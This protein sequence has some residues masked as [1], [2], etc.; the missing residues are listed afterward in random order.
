[1]SSDWLP[2]LFRP[3]L[4][5]RVRAP[6][7]EAVLITGAAQVG[8]QALA[9]VSG[10]VILRNLSPLQYAY[11][12]IVNTVLG[13]MTV[14]TDSGASSAV[15]TQGGKV[16][17]N[18]VA[19]G[20]VLS[21]GLFLRRRL[22]LFAAGAGL[23]A[24][25]ILL[26]RQGAPWLSAMFI[27]STVLPSFYLA[28]SAQLL[29][30]VPRLH[31]QLAPL[32]RNQLLTNLTRA[33]LLSLGIFALPY[34]AAAC[35]IAAIPQA[36]SNW[37]LRRLAGE[38]ADWRVP[39]DPAVQRRLALQIRRTMPSAIYFAISGQLT[40]W[41]I[42]AFGGA[43]KLATVGAL[44]RLAVA[45][46]ILGTIFSIVAVPRYARI[47]AQDADRIHRRYWQM[48][49]VVALACAGP[50]LALWLAPAPVLAILGPHYSRF[51]ADA[52]LMAAGGVVNV[53][54]IAALGLAGSRGV[55]IPP[56][57]SIPYVFL[58]QVILIALLPVSTVS[59]VLWLGLVS[60]ASHWLLL[61][62]YFAWKI[63]RRTLRE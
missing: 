58:G 36:W 28:V 32:Q 11:F 49:A 26:H 17:T 41:L 56:M 63:R 29:E 53:M 55:I 57:L 52:L 38:Y 12:T 3:L 50:L 21:T 62:V 14:L 9:F 34:A 35:L 46:G 20:A 42:A 18:R 44:G 23:P 39:A 15:L 45:F 22:A 51:A 54:N 27:A 47:P 6:W 40:V 37:Q 1:M 60:G 13:A 8:I 48:Q 4:L 2:H 7:A 33:V 25:L 31:Q 24:L 59:G 43:E 30:V 5:T 16:W 61:V 19:L 10:I